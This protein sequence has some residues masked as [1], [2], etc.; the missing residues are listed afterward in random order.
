MSHAISPV[1]RARFSSDSGPGLYSD[2]MLSELLATHEE[3]I[4]QLRLERVEVGTIA[5]FLTGEIDRHERTAAMLR[6]QL[7]NHA[8]NAAGEAGSEAEDPLS[9]SSPK[10][11]AP[12][13]APAP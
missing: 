7:E 12:R 9:R 2:Y 11:P 8:A 10:A 6:A 4:M 3:M 13:F 1:P 5:R